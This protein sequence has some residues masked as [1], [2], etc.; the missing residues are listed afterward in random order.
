[1]QC[2]APSIAWFQVCIFGSLV[3]CSI[4]FIMFYH[5]SFSRAV[6]CL[7]FVSLCVV[8]WYCIRYHV[9]YLLCVI[10]CCMPL[11]L[12]VHVFAVCFYG[13]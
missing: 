13:L 10:T 9:F 7:Y 1:M 3:F 4:C 2:H 5:G 6:L 8:N 12:C 11:D